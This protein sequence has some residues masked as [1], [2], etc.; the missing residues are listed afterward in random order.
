MYCVV[1]RP[2]SFLRGSPVIGGHEP[3]DQHG[4]F[5]L[6]T[7]HHGTHFSLRYCT[8]TNVNRTN[9]TLVTQGEK[10]WRYAGTRPNGNS[11]W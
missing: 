9:P 8:A 3:S 11:T 5:G 10:L 2:S 7:P 6:V 4:H 1:L